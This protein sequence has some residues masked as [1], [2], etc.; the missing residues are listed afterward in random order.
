MTFGIY[1]VALIFFSQ[2]VSKL[3]NKFQGF[4]NVFILAATLWL[5]I[6]F[7]DPLI[8]Q[9]NYDV[10]SL[11]APLY[12]LCILS[13]FIAAA[14]TIGAAAVLIY[15]KRIGYNMKKNKNSLIV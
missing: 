4:V 14:L 7:I 8:I 6:K 12:P 9:R 15:N 1:L 5:T 3:V 11:F 10:S 13:V 2:I